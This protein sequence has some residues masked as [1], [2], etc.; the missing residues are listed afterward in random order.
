MHSFESCCK[1]SAYVAPRAP[2]PKKESETRQQVTI[3]LHPDVLAWL[4]D[5]TGVGAR[6]KDLTHAIEFCITEQRKRE[7]K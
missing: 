1:L 2:K 4:K 7:A 6:W 3:R 5:Q